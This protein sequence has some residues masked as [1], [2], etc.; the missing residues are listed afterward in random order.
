MLGLAELVGKLRDVFVDLDD[1]P[2]DGNDENTWD[3]LPQGR[4]TA[5]RDLVNP[6]LLEGL[7]AAADKGIGLAHYALALI[8]DPNHNENSHEAGS[9]YWYAR[10]QQGQVLTGVPKEWAEAHAAH[11]ARTAKHAHHLLEAARLGEPLA[12]LDLAD[13]SGDPAFFEQGHSDVDADPAWV[14]DLAQ[15]LGR[16]GDAGKWLT[17][18]AQAGDTDA[19]RE[20]IDTHD[21]GDSSRCWTW[22]YLAELLGTDLTADDYHAVHEGGSPYDDDVGGAVYVD[23]LGGVKLAPLDVE[24]D[25]LAR[26]AAMDIFSQINCTD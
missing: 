22:I 6:I 1:D 13:Q 19:M 20:L 2:D 25:T 3:G 9:A 8:H 26:Q 10:A 12:L 21:A 17:L 23:G 24:R 14:A 16:K 18:A 4:W 11:L 15:R 5:P 7:E